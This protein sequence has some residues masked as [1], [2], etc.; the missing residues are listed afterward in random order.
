MSANSQCL[1][2][3]RWLYYLCFLHLSRCLAISHWISVFCNLYDEFLRSTHVRTHVFFVICMLISYVL[4][5]LGSRSKPRMT[6]ILHISLKRCSLY[7]K[8]TIDSHHG[9]GTSSI[10][11][12]MRR[13]GIFMWIVLWLIQ[14]NARVSSSM[15]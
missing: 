10:T 7:R 4:H 5:M 15:Q 12:P 14:G 6:Q 11:M 9:G 8:E 1:F 13:V 2:R 3:K